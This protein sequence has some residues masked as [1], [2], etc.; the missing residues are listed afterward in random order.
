MPTILLFEYLQR[1]F[2]SP[3]VN[4]PQRM[5]RNTTSKR[6]SYRGIT[7]IQPWQD[8]NFNTTWNEH[9]DVLM[10][11]TVEDDSLP[12]SPQRSVN[13]E[14]LVRAE[15]CELLRPRIR[16]DLR[17]AFA[18]TASFWGMQ[19][20]TELTFNADKAARMIH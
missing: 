13:S 10:N 5:G 3:Q 15:V 6:F 2:V 8:F 18:F 20:L 4:V 14:T 16:R 19:G 11:A 7:N 9:I 12:P 17:A 1:G